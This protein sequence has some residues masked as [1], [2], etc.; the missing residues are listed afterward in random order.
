MAAAIVGFSSLLL[1][2]LAWVA[3]VAFG[4]DSRDGDDWRCHPSLWRTT[5]SLASSE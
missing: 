1:L 5:H 3:A 2:G 4:H